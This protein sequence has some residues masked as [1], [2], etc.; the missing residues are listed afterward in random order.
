MSAW[1]GAKVSDPRNDCHELDIRPADKRAKGAATGRLPFAVLVVR[2]SIELVLLVR[3][4]RVKTLPR[5]YD[6]GGLVGELF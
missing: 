3:V 1:H 4:A 6:P 5:V 2:E